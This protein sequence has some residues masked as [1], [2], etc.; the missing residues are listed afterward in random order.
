VITLVGLGGLIVAWRRIGGPAL[1]PWLTGTV[2]LVTPSAIVQFDPRYLVC[3]IP[4]LCVAA[5]MGVQQFAALVKR[6]LG[7]RRQ[8][9]SNVH[10]GVPQP[11]PQ[12]SYG[13]A[14]TT[15]IR[16]DTTRSEPVQVRMLARSCRTRTLAVRIPR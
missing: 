15:M 16:P 9:L 1:L 14:R 8:R 2:L 10:G 13:L 6:F 12:F 5:A 3:T 11:G 7:G 4:P